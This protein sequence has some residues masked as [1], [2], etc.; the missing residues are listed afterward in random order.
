MWSTNDGYSGVSNAVEVYMN[1]TEFEST[2]YI[3]KF[4]STV[5]IASTSATTLYTST[6]N[7][8]MIEK[9]D[10][11]IV[12]MS[13]ISQFLSKLQMEHLRHILLKI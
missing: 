7:P 5:S 13:V 2:D 3:S 9:L 10:L 6:S 12:L 11:S 8:T 4:A 1:Y